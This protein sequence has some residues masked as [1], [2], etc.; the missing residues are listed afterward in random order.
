[1]INWFIS[2]TLIYCAMTKNYASK[3]YLQ[4]VQPTRY[5]VKIL[6]TSLPTSSSLPWRSIEVKE[7]GEA[8][9][10]T[11]ESVRLMAVTHLS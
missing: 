5:K 2:Q 8:Q 11:N 9:Q 1:M 6:A 10:E 4:L 3:L 7:K